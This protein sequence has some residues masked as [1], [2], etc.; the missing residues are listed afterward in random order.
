MS[1]SRVPT[2]A[3]SAT[4]S[5]SPSWRSGLTFVQNISLTQKVIFEI[6]PEFPRA[7]FVIRREA[8]R[9]ALTRALTQAADMVKRRRK[10]E[11]E[12]GRGGG[13]A[14]TETFFEVFDQAMKEAAHARRKQAVDMQAEVGG[15]KG[16]FSLSLLGRNRAGPPREGTR[17]RW[18]TVVGSP[19]NITRKGELRQQTRRSGGGGGGGGGGGAAFFQQVLLARPRDT[20]AGGACSHQA[21]DRIRAI[22][23]LKDQLKRGAA[24]SAEQATESTVTAL[25]PEQQLDLFRNEV[26]G[27]LASLETTNAKILAA[28]EK[29]EAS[30]VARE[31]SRANRR[32]QAVRGGAGQVAPNLMHSQARRTMA[33]VPDEQLTAAQRDRTELR[34]EGAIAGSRSS[35]YDA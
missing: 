12:A 1:S 5:P 7:F 23:R 24:S 32:H 33:N 20:S 19:A 17:S 10:A 30:R 4:Q 26:M 22:Q 27:R 11:A 2:S 3:T 31:A 14:R 35:P 6:L 29:S 18:N 13:G 15:E 16:P 21:N 9:M 28:L 8:L 34:E 25:S